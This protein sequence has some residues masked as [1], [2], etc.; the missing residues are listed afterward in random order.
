MFYL[1]LITCSKRTVRDD[2]SELL[3]KRDISDTKGA[4]LVIWMKP[5]DHGSLNCCLDLNLVVLVTGSMSLDQ[6]PLTLFHL[7][8][9]F[10]VFNFLQSYMDSE[11]RAIMAQYMPL[12]NQAELPNNPAPYAYAWSCEAEVLPTSLQLMQCISLRLFFGE[13]CFLADIYVYMTKT[14][15]Q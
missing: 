13:L 1:W 8:S 6:W 11:I 14:S 12:D 5:C 2:N 10:L 4:F 3:V 7:Y 15:A 9:L